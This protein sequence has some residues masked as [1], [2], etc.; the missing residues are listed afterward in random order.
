MPQLYTLVNI[1]SFLCFISLQDKSISILR[2]VGKMNSFTQTGDGKQYNFTVPF[3]YKQ[4]SFTLPS[5]GK[6]EKV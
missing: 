1:Y 5:L 6:Q 4:H 3:L 2:S